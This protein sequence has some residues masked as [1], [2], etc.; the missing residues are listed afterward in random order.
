MLIPFKAYFEYTFKGRLSELF[1]EN[2]ETYLERSSEDSQTVN[3]ANFIRIY[4]TGADLDIFKKD[5]KIDFDYHTRHSIYPD[6]ISVSDLNQSI[7][8]KIKSD[9]VEVLQILGDDITFSNSKK[10]VKTASITDIIH[11][12]KL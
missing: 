1:K 3:T 6:T 7:E 8:F 2:L 10:E 9:E 12:I 11:L 4:L 5:R